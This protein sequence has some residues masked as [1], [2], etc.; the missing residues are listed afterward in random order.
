[1]VLLKTTDE[2]AATEAVGLYRER[3]GTVGLFENKVY[4]GIV[5]CLVRLRDEGHEL[6]IATS[7]PRVFAKRIIEHFE[8]T[9]YFSV[10]DGSELDGTRCDKTSLLAYILEQRDQVDRDEAV[11]IGDRKFDMDGATANGIPGIGVL[12]G[13]GT[14]DELREAGASQCAESPSQLPAALKQ[15]MS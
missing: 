2:S 1:M 11:M 8:L 9:E 12:W 15:A 5:D 6:S 14:I 10:V 3:F 7:K 4:P 13:Y